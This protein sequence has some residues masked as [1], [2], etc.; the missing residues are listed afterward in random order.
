M[1]ISELKILLKHIA[2]NRHDYLSPPEVYLS[3]KEHPKLLQFYK[4]IIS[5]KVKTDEEAAEL[6][7]EKN[8]SSKEYTL[9]KNMLEERI[10]VLVL[11]I[12]PE[13]ALKAM[14]SRNI[15][16]SYRHLLSGYLLRCMPATVTFADDLWDMALQKG[17][18]IHDPSISMLAHLWKSDLASLKNKGED[19]YNHKQQFNEALDRFKKESTLKLYEN[20]LNL[21][22]AGS[23]M[24]QYRFVAKAKKYYDE[25]KKIHESIKSYTSYLSFAIIGMRYGFFSKN[26]QLVIDMAN[27][28]DELIKKNP[29]YVSNYLSA[30]SS[31]FRM[32]GYMYLRKYEEGKKEARIIISN[33]KTG[34]RDWLAI[35]EYYFLLCMHSGNYE[36]ALNV[37]YEG[38]KS[39]YFQNL[40]AEYQ[41]RWKYFEPYLNF[42]IP[43]QFPKE[44]INLL[45]FL[46]E[47]SYYTSHKGD[48]NI[49]IMIGQ[50]IVMLDMLEF[51]K[52][53]ERTYFLENYIKKHVEKKIY[54]RTFIF[55]NMLLNLFKNNFDVNKTHK[56]VQLQYD[57]LIPFEGNKLFCIEDIEVIPY[58]KLWDVIREKLNKKT[59]AA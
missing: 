5:G 19:F 21:I 45:G 43:D 49:V 35:L 3:D 27:L 42:I 1:E 37:Y 53:R 22:Q 28:R 9:L 18:F 55:L 24:N 23:H 33:M 51:E 41:E 34:N 8:S 47:M 26:Y 58:E 12:D 56:Q 40:N 7:L 38:F 10:S 29:Q 15:F 17:D 14:A 59:K 2:D 11:G 30:M 50:I 31:T 13:K 46:D 32:V 39:D 44:A 54:P 6:L 57:K 25:A 4:H 20:E 16:R 48:N 52:L 36:Q